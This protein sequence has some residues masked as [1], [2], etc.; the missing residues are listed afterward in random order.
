MIYK[1]AEVKDWEAA[2]SS[3]YFE[4]SDLSVEG[5]IHCCTLQQIEY[6]L[7]KHFKDKKDLLILEI[8]ESKISTLLK[9]EDLGNRGEEFPH[10][11]GSLPVSAILR[12]TALV[13]EL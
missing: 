3:K 5:F 7:K 11:Y 9:W 13:E 1:I 2:Q 6:V 10:I 12:C 4:S 8:D